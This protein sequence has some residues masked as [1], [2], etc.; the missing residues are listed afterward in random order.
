MRITGRIRPS[1]F[2]SVF[3]IIL[4]VILLFFVLLMII[5]DVGTIG[6]IFL[7]LI[8]LPIG[9]HAYNLVAPAGVAEFDMAPQDDSSVANGSVQ[10]RLQVLDDLKNKGLVSEAEYQRKKK[11]I[12]D[13]L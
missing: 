9:Y 10:Q 3:A 7:V 2:V 1:K 13:S 11:Q 6:W 5:P 8:L 12:L 4:G